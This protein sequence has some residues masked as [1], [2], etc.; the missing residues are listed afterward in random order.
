MIPVL[1][2]LLPRWDGFFLAAARYGLALPFL[3]A[4]LKLR[5]PGRLMPAGVP[6]WR[7]LVLGAVG[8]GAFAPLFTV[9]VAHAN[10]VTAAILSAS[11]PVIA[12]FVAWLVDRAPVDRRLLPGIMLVVIGGAVATVDFRSGG[13]LFD[14]RGGEPLMIAGSFCW[15]WASLTAQRWLA[16]CSQLRIATL[17]L[18]PGVAVLF[19]VD[20]AAIPIGLAHWPP[21]LRGGFDAGLF[22][23]MGLVSVL[24]GLLLWNHGV[25]VLG[26]VVASFFLNLIPVA[27]V[28]ITA[29]LGTLPTAWQLAGGALVLT[30]VMQAQRRRPAHAR[31]RDE[32]A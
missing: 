18:L 11:G 28:L 3:L 16:G 12:L 27:A 5:E 30:G 4:A 29:M 7:I 19:I 26:V 10:P 2:L 14:L 1:N 13:R 21:P 32:H 31:H 8:I 20:L 6:R 22:L 9:G 25:R 23:W 15:T 24:A 17:L